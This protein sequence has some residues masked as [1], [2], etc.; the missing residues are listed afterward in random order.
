MSLEEW[1]AIGIPDDIA[2]EAMEW[3]AILD[4]DVCSLRQQQDFQ[5]WLD[6]DPIHLWAFEELSEFWAKTSFAEN[7]MNGLTASLIESNDA[8]Q[9]SSKRYNNAAH[10]AIASM[11]I[12]LI[13]SFL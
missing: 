13:S 6:I 7:E 3:I 1:M 2:D 8:Q 9:P 10:F 12:G 5:H 11:I 4:S